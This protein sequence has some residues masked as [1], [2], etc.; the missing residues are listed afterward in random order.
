MNT[1]SQP[2]LANRRGVKVGTATQLWNVG[3]KQQLL[4]CTL[5]TII[6]HTHPPYHIPQSFE[7][8]EF[9]Y[10]SPHDPAPGLQQ[11]RRQYFV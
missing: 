6:T 1:R 9:C 5:S 8:E 2:T 11:W 7:A 4:G 10:P 3:V